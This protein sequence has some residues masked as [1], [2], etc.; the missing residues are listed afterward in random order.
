MAPEPVA[1]FVSIRTTPG[2]T[3]SIME[4]NNS[5]GVLVG[6]GTGLGS[7]EHMLW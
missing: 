5:A 7:S 4:V 6:V 2:L 1:R 3:L